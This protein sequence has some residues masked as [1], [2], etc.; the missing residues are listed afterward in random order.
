MFQVSSLEIVEDE[1]EG[2][3]D[4]SV[5]NN[6]RLFVGNIPKS[7]TRTEILLEFEQHAGKLHL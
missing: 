2:Q 6:T 7:K 1:G 5:R 4:N 3:A